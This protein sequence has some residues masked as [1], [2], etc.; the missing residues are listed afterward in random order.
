MEAIRSIFFHF[1]GFQSCAGFNHEAL[2]ASVIAAI[3][4]IAAEKELSLP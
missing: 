1:V 2:S 4:V 3:S